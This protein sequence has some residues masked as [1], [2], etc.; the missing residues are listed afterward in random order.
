MRGL[1]RTVLGL[2]VLVLVLVGVDRGGDLVAEQQAAAGLAATF[3]SEPDVDIRGFPFLTQWA[4]GRYD[5]IAVAG[6][7]VLLGGT[8]AK[9]I[10]VTLRDVRTD[11]FLTNGNV[12][13]VHAGTASMAGTVPFDALPLPRGISAKRAGDTGDRMRLSGT[14]SILDQD[15]RISAV[16]TVSLQDGDARLKPQ[17]VKVLGPLPSVA[18]TALVRDH[19]GASVQLAGLPPGLTAA[20]L[21]VTDTGVRVHAAG[22]DVTLRTQR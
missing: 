14:V 10:H 11:P 7:S 4:S 18:A 20:S 21:S 12:D 19:L 6:Q 3:G 13:S 17:Q 5:T 15:V 22:T 16:V 8:R 1:R 2:A 9:N